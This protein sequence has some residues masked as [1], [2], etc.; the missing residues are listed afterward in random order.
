MSSTTIQ[1]NLTGTAAGKCAVR[2][3]HYQ[4]DTTGI[5]CMGFPDNVRTLRVGS[6]LHLPSGD[7]AWLC[8]DEADRLEGCHRPNRFGADDEIVKPPNLLLD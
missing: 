4:V 6:D 2:L 3:V 1:R 8:S 5:D 7:C